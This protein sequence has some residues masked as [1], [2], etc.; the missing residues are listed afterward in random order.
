MVNKHPELSDFG[1]TEETISSA[2]AVYDRVNLR[3]G[4]LLL[5]IS[6]APMICV[7]ALVYPSAKNIGHAI[8]VALFVGGL[9]GTMA[10]V[11]LGILIAVLSRW[12]L[13]NYTHARHMLERFEKFNAAVRAYELEQARRQAE[14]WSLIS[15]TRFEYE[16][17]NLFRRHGF[18]ASVTSQS[19]DQGIDIIMHMDDEEVIVQC[20]RH[21]K[22]VGP[23]VA[24]ELYGALIASG[25]QS[26]FLVCPSGFTK[27]VIEFVR[28]KPI[29]LLDIDGIL[30]LAKTAS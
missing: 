16:I 3:T 13:P 18:A 5:G 22:P 30:K 20:K 15:P 21:G 17:A 24:R 7:F 14:Y 27:G 11:A 25:A 29:T 23:A 2:R 10:F 19:G 1:L 8:F 26:A 12:L 4:I 28:D 9:L 6:I